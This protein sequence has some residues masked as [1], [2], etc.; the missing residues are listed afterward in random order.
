MRYLLISGPI[1]SSTPDKPFQIF[2]EDGKNIQPHSL[3]PE[4][5]TS[6]PERMKFDQIES[7]EDIVATGYTYYK[8]EIGQYEG[9]DKARIDKM[10]ASL[11]DEQE[12]E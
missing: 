4:D 6:F 3:I 9:A 12:A 11:E 1:G 10:I 8:I 7:L 5:V 2:I